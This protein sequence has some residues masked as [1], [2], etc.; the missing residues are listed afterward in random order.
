M[1]E[2]K[3]GAIPTFARVDRAAPLG[4]APQTPKVTTVVDMAEAELNGAG[5]ELAAL[6]DRLNPVLAVDNLV[7]DMPEMLNPSCPMVEKLDS[8]RRQAAH[9]ASRIRNITQRLEV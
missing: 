6:E 7:A 3:Q 4:A 1:S 8:L 2:R 9:L 5:D